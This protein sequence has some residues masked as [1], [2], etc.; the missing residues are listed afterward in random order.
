ML[1]A[2]LKPMAEEV[3]GPTRE[4]SSLVHLNW[5]STQ[6]P[7]K[8]FIYTHGQMLVLIRE[9]SV[10]NSKEHRLIAGQGLRVNDGWGLN[11]NQYISPP[12]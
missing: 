3:S 5:Q 9:T 6:L 8:N 4:L 1:G 2:Q 11:P 12:L 7:F 10:M